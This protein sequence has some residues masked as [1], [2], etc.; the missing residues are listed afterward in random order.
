MKV[1]SIGGALLLLCLVSL[2]SAAQSSAREKDVQLPSSKLPVVACSRRTAAYQQ[3]SHSG[4]AQSRWK[5]PR[6]F[7]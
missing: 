2:S 5:V 1:R 6:H 4:G 7:E 3:F